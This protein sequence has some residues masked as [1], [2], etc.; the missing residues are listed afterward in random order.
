MKIKKLL[1][2]FLTFN[3]ISI[4]SI[5][6][7]SCVY[8]SEVL[9]SKG[10]HSMINLIEDLAKNYSGN[11]EFN[12][13]PIGS[14]SSILALLNNENDLA[15]SS[16]NPKDILY[17]F[18]QDGH[19]QINQDIY[20]KW[21]DKEIKIAKIANEKMAFLLKLPKGY[22]IKNY[23]FSKE[24]YQKI[25]EAFSG[26]RELKINDLLDEDEHYGEEKNLSILPFYKDGGYNTSSVALAFAHPDYNPYNINLENNQELLATGKLGTKSNVIF[27]QDNA[28]QSFKTFKE[29]DSKAKII[30]LNYSYFKNN[31]L[32]SNS[33]KNSGF[34]ILKN[35]SED[36]EFIDVENN[37]Y[38][39]NRSLYLA[40]SLKNTK[41]LPK[42]Y[43]FLKS[44]YSFKKEGVKAIYEN[45]A[46]S[47][48]K[49]F[50]TD[51]KDLSQIDD[52]YWNNLIAGITKLK[53]D[54]L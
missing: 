28:T 2:S 51:E 31:N 39:F 42:I 12:I 47:L 37:N 26:L 7:S 19:K 18:D 50:F 21:R 34:F 52:T 38:I 22:E 1:Y 6:A 23:H 5:F 4:S 15:L 32:N 14:K 3:S 53:F 48:P 29:Y 8:N 20:N 25:L 10:S 16:V 33:A 49:K 13:I 44:F 17:S 11:A 41:K 46:V 40:F 35:K 24:N 36:N 43:S 30:V 45:N 27:T 9:N 54:N